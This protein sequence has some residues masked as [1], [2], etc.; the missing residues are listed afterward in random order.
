MKIVRTDFLEVFAE[1]DQSHKNSK[2]IDEA[3]IGEHGDE[4]DV[5][6]LISVQ[7]LHIDTAG[8]RS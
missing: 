5:Q 4:I 8:T 7:F 2:G 1:P 3:E 6:L